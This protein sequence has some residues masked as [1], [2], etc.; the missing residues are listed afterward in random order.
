M[1]I[2]LTLFFYFKNV[3]RPQQIPKSTSRASV[4]S[5]SGS[6]GGSPTSEVP[7]VPL[8]TRPQPPKDSGPPPIPERQTPGMG[9]LGR[10]GS[11][12]SATDLLE[13]LSDKKSDSRRDSQSK[14]TFLCSRPLSYNQAKHSHGSGFSVCALYHLYFRL[15]SAENIIFHPSACIFPIFSQSGTNFVIRSYSMMNGTMNDFISNL[16]L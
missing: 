5:A 10:L 13:Q 2:F 8:S 15:I 12:S 3:C 6:R 16:I 9:S 14:W 4:S 1:T 7:P 11:L